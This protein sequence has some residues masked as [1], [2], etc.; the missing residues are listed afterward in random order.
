MTGYYYE[1]M[2][3]YMAV[4]GNWVMD[5]F[6][7]VAETFVPKKRSGEAN[8]LDDT[9]MS[10]IK[11]MD[12][13]YKSLLIY[14][15]DGAFFNVSSGVQN[16]IEPRRLFTI[17]RFSGK[18][19]PLSDTELSFFLGMKALKIAF[20]CD[21]E[22]H[23]RQT[24]DNPSAYLLENLDHS[25]L[26]KYYH[27]LMRMEMIDVSGNPGREILLPGIKFVPAYK[28]WFGAEATTLLGKEKI[29]N[30]P[31]A[32][33]VKM[34]NHHVIEMQ[35]FDQLEQSDSAESRH[36]QWSVQKYFELDKLEIAKY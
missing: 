8:D 25:R 20:E 9:S 36:R 32:V 11:E 7:N 22:Y 34:Y 12:F 33:S 21:T 19:T 4:D 14:D 2:F 27:T 13:E 23:F 24:T 18:K 28:I 1:F 15:A 35:L 17:V 3:D 10:K 26:P 5:F 29:M 30:F 31:D 6:R 16:T